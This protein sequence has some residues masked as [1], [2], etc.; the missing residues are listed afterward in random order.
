MSEHS[1]ACSHELAS[2]CQYITHIKTDMTTLVRACSYYPQWGA[3]AEFAAAAGFPE[4]TASGENI[5]LFVPGELP[6][7][8]HS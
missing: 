8:W 5:T 3:A 4:N 6:Q 7:A 1:K 2:S